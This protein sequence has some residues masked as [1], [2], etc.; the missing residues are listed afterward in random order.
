MRRTLLALLLLPQDDAPNGDYGYFHTWP[1]IRAKM[2][3]LKKSHPDL[4]HETVLGKTLEGRDIPLFKISDHAARDEDEPEVCLMA[5]IHPREQPPQILLL[6]L[7]EEMLAAYGKDERITRL[8]NKR[9]IW[10]IPVFNVDGKVYDMKHGNGKD[11]GAEWRKNRRK[12]P[13][14]TVG[15]DLNRQFPVR[16]GGSSK[17]ETNSKS[18]YFVG[19]GPMTEPEPRALVTFF[20]ERSLRA[21]VDIHSPFKAIYHANWLIQPEYDR[22]MTMVRRMRQLQETPYDIESHKPDTEP[23]AERGGDC[24]LTYDVAY[25]QFGIYAFI[26]EIYAKP[27]WYPPEDQIDAEYANFKEPMLYV[28]EE[29]ANLPVRKKGSATVKS[30]AADRKI[31]PGARV[32]WTPAV[33]GKCDYGVLVSEDP[34]IRVTSEFRIFPLKSGFVLQI[35]KDARLGTKVPMALYLWDRERALSVVRFSLMVEAP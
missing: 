6:R 31:E 2:A 11:H 15:I 9:E 18:D 28:I 23:P 7:L 3:A 10:I 17:T 24:G 4:V 21:F 30:S 16:W 19:Y 20:E 1:E 13:D 34:A 22:F 29:A 14:G 12:N 8:I 35:P 5:A 32:V 33:E 25:Y 27:K 26:F